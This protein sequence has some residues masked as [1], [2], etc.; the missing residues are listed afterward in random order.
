MLLS[1]LVSLYRKSISSSIFLR[2][3]KILNYARNKACRGNKYVYE[4]NMDETKRVYYM[5]ISEKRLNSKNFN[6]ITQE[7]LITV[8]I[9]CEK[10]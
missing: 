10:I 1:S 8:S 3:G 9:F 5:Y 7:T 4:Y 6:K 2:R